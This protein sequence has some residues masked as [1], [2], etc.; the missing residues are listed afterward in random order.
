VPAPEATAAAS[1]RAAPGGAG[2]PAR[3]RVAAAVPPAARAAVTR[4]ARAGTVFRGDVQRREFIAF[5]LG[6]GRVLAGMNVN[7]FGVNDTI[8]AIV[9][10]VRTVD[11]GRLA[12]PDVPLDDF[13]G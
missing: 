12:D 10:A 2:R 3:A 1:R 7:I 11:P 5:W 9:R 6:G 4:A 8:Q 13:L